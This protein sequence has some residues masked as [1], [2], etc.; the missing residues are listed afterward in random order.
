MKYNKTIIIRVSE[1]EKKYFSDLAKKQ[2]TTVSKIIRKVLFENEKENISQNFDVV[3]ITRD[4]YGVLSDNTL[5]KTTNII[6]NQIVVSKI[7]KWCELVKNKCFIFTKNEI[8]ND[9]FNFLQ[10]ATHKN[11]NYIFQKS[12]EFTE[13]KIKQEKREQLE[14]EQNLLKQKI[15]Q[16]K[17]KKSKI[18]IFSN[19]FL[20]NLKY[21]YALFLCFCG[22]AICLF[23][24]YYYISFDFIPNFFN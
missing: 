2:K 17:I 8:L 13:Q 22:I 11:Q 21:I 14:R 3:Q 20:N 7:K 5:N 1:K 10:F 6:I 12:I 18:Y 16:E 24:F 19:F 15:K 23:S 9:Q 4:K